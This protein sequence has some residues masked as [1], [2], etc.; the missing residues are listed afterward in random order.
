MGTLHDLLEAKG[1][2]ALLQLGHDRSL[3]EAATS[4]MSDEDAGIGFLFSGWTQAALP[5]RR[6]A[7]DAVWQVKS[8]AVTLLVEPGRRPSATGDVPDYVGVPYGSRARLIM[9][10]LQSEALRR[11][12][13]EVQLGKTLNA[14]L[15]RMGIS[16]GG[17]TF[18]DVKDQA[19]RISRCR[20]TFHAAIGRGRTG[21]VNQNIVDAAMFVD[22]GEQRQTSLFSSTVQLSV[23]FFEQLQKHPVP[24]DE[25]AIRVISNN[26]MALDIYCWLAYRLHCLTSPKLITWAGLMP[27]FG[28]G[29]RLVKHFKPKFLQNLRLAMAVYPDARVDVADNG[30]VLHNSRP[31][32]APKALSSR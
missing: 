13:R 5:H 2:Q 7:D 24:L 9:L 8:D 29:F 16:V 12:S 32:V 28:G 27:Q 31:P 11:N 3:V 10:Y 4:F 18:L 15:C 23:G 21:L 17:K 26:S 6:L 22:E 1:K 14:W 30:V 19:D 25:A 20:L